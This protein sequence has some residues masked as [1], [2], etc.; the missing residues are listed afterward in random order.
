MRIPD[1]Y[2]GTEWKVQASVELSLEAGCYNYFNNVQSEVKGEP[3][4]LHLE[5]TAR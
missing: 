3:N 4:S 2:Q 5:N 1:G